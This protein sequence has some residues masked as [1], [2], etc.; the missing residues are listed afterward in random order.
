MK[1]VEYNG[2]NAEE[3]AFM[4]SFKVC[5]AIAGG[6]L[7]PTILSFS[8]GWV[9]WLQM[10]LGVCT[11]VYLIAGTLVHLIE[12][13]G[14]G[15]GWGFRW[16]RKKP[17]W[18]RHRGF[19]VVTRGEEYEVA[20]KLMGRLFVLTGTSD[21]LRPRSYDEILPFKTEAEAQEWLSQ[22]KEKMFPS[23]SGGWTVVGRVR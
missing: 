18:K 11:S 19:Y 15:N 2:S 14:E 20:V 5:V 8:L 7:A 13:I 16:G 10:L 17:I 1:I 22:A 21:P 23:S 12:G 3:A 6:A 9:W 4:R